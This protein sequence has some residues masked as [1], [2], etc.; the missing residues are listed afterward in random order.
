MNNLMISGKDVTDDLLAFARD[1]V[2]IK[3]YSG[4]EE[5]VA[6][7]IASK[8]ESLGY[9]EVRI[10]HIGNVLG[11]IGN[12]GKVIL[13][14]SHIDTVNVDDEDLWAVP[15]FSGEIVDG[16][17]WGRGSV[18]MKSGVAAAVYA[19]VVAKSV[20]WTIGKTVYV[21]CT[22]FEEDCDGEG[23]RQLLKE[24]RLK[25]EYA[26][27]CEPSANTIVT[28]QKG[29]AQ[30]IIRTQGVSAHSS[31]PE[32]GE[33][34][35]YAMAGI[36]Q[37]VE[38]ANLDLMK[39]DGRRGSLVLSQISSKS[40]SI[41]AVPSECEAY[42]DRRMV[43]GDTEKTIR[44]EMEKIVAGINAEWEM[45]ILHRTTWTGAELIYDPFHLAWEISLDHNLSRAF[46]KAY[47]DVFGNSPEKFDFWD[48]ST[49]A[50]ALVDLGIPTIG[51]GPG[52]YKL[53]HMRDEKCATNQI[54][55]ACSVYSAVID[56]L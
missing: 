7:F 4:Q 33:N 14:D 11:R 29:K 32:K 24:Y 15:P 10:D 3:S 30:I 40:V 47:R 9:D 42:L 50:V 1:L 23:L 6:R 39:A 16:F 20:G 17:L 5:Q 38:Q 45:D 54:M 8:M 26:V 34:A 31:A 56:M 37:R 21:S 12:G 49:N 55:D 51:F 28:G 13:F 35:I 2:R 25:P 27:I 48:F 44:D 53:A 43:L 41:N 46:I 19:A 22:V 18:D 36:I 52:E